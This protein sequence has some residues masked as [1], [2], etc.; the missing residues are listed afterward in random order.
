MKLDQS[1]LETVIPAVGKRVMIVNGK[2]HALDVFRSGQVGFYRVCITEDEIDYFIR[3][4]LTI[5]T[6]IFVFCCAGANRGTVA[7]LRSLN[8][9][10]FSC[11]LTLD[12]GTRKGFK[13]K[14]VAYEDVCKL[15][16]S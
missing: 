7:I 9:E 8:V 16:D 14:N 12:A 6:D 15:A 5:T 3:D 1:H 10:S 13:V 11:D 2:F 4:L